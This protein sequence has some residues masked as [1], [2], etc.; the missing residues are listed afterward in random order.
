MLSNLS[1]S[2]RERQIDAYRG[3]AEP[4]CALL[5]GPPGTGKT[6][7]LAWMILGYLVVSSVLI[8]SLG[9]LGDIESYEK[10]T[11]LART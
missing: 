5:L 3:L 6:T 1:S 2:L 8:V 9:R 11:G 7:L 10:R 4:R